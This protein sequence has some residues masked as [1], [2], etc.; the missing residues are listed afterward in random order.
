MRSSKSARRRG[1][2][3]G[4]VVLGVI[5]GVALV[6]VPAYAADGTKNCG[7]NQWPITFSYTP[8]NAG[9]PNSHRHVNMTGPGDYTDT[10]WEGGNFTTSPS[11]HYDQYTLAGSNK[12]VW[13]A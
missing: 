2:V 5:A 3:S 8:P 6:G 10:K 7:N 9:Q 11:W 4:G 13:C 1:L 12:G